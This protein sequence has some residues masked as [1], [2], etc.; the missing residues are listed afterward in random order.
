MKTFFQTILVLLIAVAASYAGDP[1]DSSKAKAELPWKP[2]TD[3]F[4]EA[5]KNDKKIM[6]DIYTDWC[7]WC[8][9]LDA[10]VYSDPDVAAYLKAHYVSVKLNAESKTQVTYKDTAYSQ[11]GFAQ[12][13][14]VTGYP[15]IAFFDSHGDFITKLGGYVGPERFLPIVKF[16]GED[17][18]K[19]MSWDDYQKQLSQKQADQQKV[20][21][22]N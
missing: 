21:K 11:V 1:P 15:T 8:K 7:G 4:A 10:N 12:A 14:G 22:K 3:G 9:R 6:L 13:L 5:K 2:F 19:K 20:D 16:I 17:Y 18:Y